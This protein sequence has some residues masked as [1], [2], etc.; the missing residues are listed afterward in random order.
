MDLARNCLPFGG[1]S[2]FTLAGLDGMSVGVCSK[3]QVYTAAENPTNTPWPQDC[4]IK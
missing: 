1:E 2:I 3:R 4:P